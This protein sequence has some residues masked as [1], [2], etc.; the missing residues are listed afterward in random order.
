MLPERRTVLKY[1][2]PLSDGNEYSFRVSLRGRRV[3]VRNNFKY[4]LKRINKDGSSMW[5][6][7]YRT[8]CKCNGTIALNKESLVVSE[9]DHQCIMKLIRKEDLWNP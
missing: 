9:K 1:L 8:T 5:R 3:L 7:V 4:N 2:K 6:C